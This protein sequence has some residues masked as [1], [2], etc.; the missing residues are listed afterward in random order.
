MR[1]RKEPMASSYISNLVGHS[2]VELGPVVLGCVRQAVASLG[3]GLMA[4]QEKMV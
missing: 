3:K 2:T 4:R 1:Q